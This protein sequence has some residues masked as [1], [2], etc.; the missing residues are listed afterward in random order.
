[1]GLEGAADDASGGGGGYGDDDDGELFSLMWIAIVDYCDDIWG[2]CSATRRGAI[3]K[4]WDQRDNFWDFDSAMAV[5]LFLT[6]LDF[7]LFGSIK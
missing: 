4:F 5:V 2:M 3:V 6:M 7:E 1:M